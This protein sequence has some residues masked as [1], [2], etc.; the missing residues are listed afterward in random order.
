MRRRD[1]AGMALQNTIRL[2]S[3]SVLTILSIAI[4]V[5]AVYMI[6]SICS[7]GQKL[8]KTEIE[9]LGI[10]G[11]SLYAEINGTAGGKLDISF[12]DSLKEQFD[13]IEETMPLVTSYGSLSIKGTRIDSIFLGADENLPEMMGVTLLHGRLFGTQDIRR[14]RHVAVIDKSLAKSV[15]QREN[16]VGKT[17][18]VAIGDH[19]VDFEIIGIIEPQTTMLDGLSG[20]RLPEFIYIPYTTANA[21]N[22]TNKADQIAIRCYADVDTQ[23]AADTILSV[24]N[25]NSKDQV[26]AI[27]NINGYIGQIE[28]LIGLISV[29]LTVIAGISLFVA[30]IG[31]MSRM[32]SSVIERKKEIGIW[33][34]LGAQEKD[35]FQILL[36]ESVFLCMIGG[37]IGG[38]V[39]LMLVELFKQMIGL[40]HRIELHLLIVPIAIAFLIGI[41]FGTL[42][43]R[44]AA[45]LHPSDLLRET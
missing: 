44:K 20:G 3:K 43:S 30:G 39:G 9:R 22:H 40:S 24:L 45:K 11:L 26:Y 10:D 5:A 32:L 36:T 29:L 6:L 27:E 28:H 23:T 17:I 33:L 25:R 18:H 16:I 8:V 37:V 2:K 1:I 14:S 38:S 4:G 31:V 15:Y 21:M 34:A 42:P 41:L 12:V 19:S 35:V 7:S 13:F